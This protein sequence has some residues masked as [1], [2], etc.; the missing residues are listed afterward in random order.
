MLIP[1]LPLLA[2]KSS[3]HSLACRPIASLP[4]EPSTLWCLPVSGNH[5]L[6]SRSVTQPSLEVSLPYKIIATAGF[7]VIRWVLWGALSCQH[8]GLGDS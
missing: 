4:S 5:L 6:I 2:P 8:G 1:P 7:R 3:L